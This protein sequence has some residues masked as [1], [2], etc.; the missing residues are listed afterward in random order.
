MHLRQ[1]RRLGIAAC[2]V[3]EGK[4][5]GVAEGT[6]F[7]GIAFPSDA[8]SRS[9][10]SLS[11]GLCKVTLPLGVI[12]VIYRYVIRREL[13]YGLA[14]LGISFRALRRAWLF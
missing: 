3:L 12:E 8:A 1:P 4:V 14:I 9:P 5:L 11:R 13:N 6:P 2:D 7:A 10:P